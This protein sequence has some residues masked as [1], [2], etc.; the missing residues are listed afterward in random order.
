MI[1]ANR[2]TFPLTSAPFGLPSRSPLEVIRHPY[3]PC[4]GLRYPDGPA[5]PVVGPHTPFIKDAPAV[6]PLEYTLKVVEAGSQKVVSRVKLASRAEAKAALVL[7][8]RTGN[9][10]ILMRGGLGEFCRL[11]R[12]SVHVPLSL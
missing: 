3:W 9:Q 1:P 8:G 5:R 11:P 4:C 10:T 6:V 7:L 12:Q 2:S